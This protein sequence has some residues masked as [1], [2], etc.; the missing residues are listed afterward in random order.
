MAYDNSNRGALWGNENREKETSP[1]FKGTIN[2]NGVDYWL[3]AWRRKPDANPSAP[4]LSLSVKA[5]EEKPAKEAPQ[6]GYK[7]T[8]SFHEPLNDDIPF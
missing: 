5:K 8:S 7:Q 2:V 6:T 1:D 4:A 3:S